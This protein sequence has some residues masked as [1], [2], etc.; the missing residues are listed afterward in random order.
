MESCHKTKSKSGHC[1]HPQG[2]LDFEAT[3]WAA[4]EIDEYGKVKG[5]EVTIPEE[6]E[7]TDAAE[8]EFNKSSLSSS[9]EERAGVRSR[10]YYFDGGPVEIAVEI[11]H[12][13]KGE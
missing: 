5:T 10:K 8:S 6:P 12:D 7:S 4:E 9:M 11:V 1:G 13:C 3:L 2:H